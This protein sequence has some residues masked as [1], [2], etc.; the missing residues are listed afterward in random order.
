MTGPF[1]AAQRVAD[2]V[3]YE[4]YVLYP[5]H[6]SSDKN[7]VRFQFGV[8]APRDFSEADRSESWEMQTEC[9]L[10]DAGEARLDLRVRFLQLQSRVVEAVDPTVR[11]RLRTGRLARGGRRDRRRVG[12][13]RRAP[14]R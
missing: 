9:L 4:G 5:Y 14:D 1:E 3:L 13:S 11:G 12:R 10:T 6:A 8:V 2:A 7:R